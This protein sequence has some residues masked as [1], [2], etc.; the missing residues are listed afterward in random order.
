[1]R[2]ISSNLISSS[3]HYYLLSTV[4]P[5]TRYFEKSSSSQPNTASDDTDPRNPCVRSHGTGRRIRDR[6]GICK[7][8]C[9]D[10]EK[11]TINFI[12]VKIERQ[13]GIRPRLDVRRTS[14]VCAGLVCQ[15]AL[16]VR[17]R[18]RSAG[19]FRVPGRQRNGHAASL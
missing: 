3:G 8:E 9:A 4:I 2:L 10:G 5:S 1:M 16:N 18:T 6:D 11:K 17:D 12:F 7:T 15:M 14:T 19:S 13:N